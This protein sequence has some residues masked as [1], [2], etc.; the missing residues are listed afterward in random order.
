LDSR[1]DKSA[2]AEWRNLELNLQDFQIHLEQQC[3]IYRIVHK[4]FPVLLHSNGRD[5]SAHIGR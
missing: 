1:E 2:V 3:S 5:P 4:V